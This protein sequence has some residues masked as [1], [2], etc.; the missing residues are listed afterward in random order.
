MEPG[1]GSCPLPLN[2]VARPGGVSPILPLS[3]PGRDLDGPATPPDAGSSRHQ[4]FNLLGRPD[5]EQGLVEVG[6]LGRRL[7]RVGAQPD[8]GPVPVVGSQAGQAEHG[9]EVV[10]G[11]LL[12][13][14]HYRGEDVGD[15]GP[16]T[17]LG[18]K[19]WVRTRPSLCGPHRHHVLQRRI[20]ACALHLDWRGLHNRGTRHL[21]S[22]AI[23]S[24]IFII[25]IKRYKVMNFLEVA[26]PAA[27]LQPVQELT[28]LELVPD[29]PAAAPDIKGEI[30]RFPRLGP[31]A[32]GHGSSLCAA[33]LV[34]LLVPFLPRL[35]V[36]RGEVPLG[37]AGLTE[38]R[39]R[40]LVRMRDV[41]RADQLRKLRIAVTMKL[42]GEAIVVGAV[43]TDPLANSTLPDLPAERRECLA[44]APPGLLRGLFRGEGLK[45]CLD[46]DQCFEPPL[47]AAV[48]VIAVAAVPQ[49]YDVVEPLPH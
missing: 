44:Q 39:Q 43:L 32:L 1:P 14:R 26:L 16:I 24:K 18:G 49:A 47:S 4:V 17:F 42:A 40:D 41:V 13:R 48:G 25:V 20:Q 35:R 31:L 30:V 6:K 37:R 22:P 33:L 7:R 10:A 27:F 29:S 3:P 38:F 46:D 34:I 36:D 23:F 9:L 2:G 11:S 19:T 28:T 5:G 12:E 8:P 45:L 15:L 21:R